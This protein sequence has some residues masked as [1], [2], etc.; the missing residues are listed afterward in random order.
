MNMSAWRRWL[1]PQIILTLLALL[2]AG[3]GGAGGGGTASGSGSPTTVATPPPCNGPAPVV[4]VAPTVTLRN[5]DAYHTASV[6]LGSVVEIRLDGKHKWSLGGV[7]PSG[8]LTTV[9]AQGTL[10]QG[11]CV[12]D[13]TVAQPGDA[14]V[15]FVGTA[16]CAPNMP[17]PQYAML[18]KF[19]IHAV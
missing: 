6:P 15:S 12:W 3:C 4:G 19:I 16:L 13:F 2:V 8:A 5:T 10:M 7:A 18:I 9:G 11:E 17:C 1:A 14:T